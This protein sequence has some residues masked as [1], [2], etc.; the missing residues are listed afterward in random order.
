M[1]VDTFSLSKTLRTAVVYFALVFGAGFL[2]GSIRVAFVVPRIGE[3]Y[4]EL[5]EMP[6]M[7]L[8]IYFASRYVLRRRDEK[9]DSAGLIAV[10]VIALLLLVG[11]ELLFA[12]VLAGRGIGEYIS[13]RDRVSGGVYLVMLVVFAGMP[14]LQARRRRAPL[15]R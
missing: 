2:L 12:A 13:S 8:A 7:F 15:E 9:T 1:P 10:G 11:A 14:W 4:A 5:V 6:L 3:R